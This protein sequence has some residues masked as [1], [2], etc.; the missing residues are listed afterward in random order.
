MGSG[1]GAGTA[2]LVPPPFG[3]HEERGVT[4]EY[5]MRIEERLAE[6]RARID[7]AGGADRVTLVAVTKGFGPEAP[8]AALAAGVADFGENYAQELLA[9]AAAPGLGAARWHFLGALQTNKAPRLAPVVHRW[10]GIDRLAA[11]VAVGRRRPGAEVFVEVNI[12]R[13]PGRAGCTPEATA[14]LVAA[15]GDTGVNV[16]GL[17]GVAP[18]GDRTAAQAGFRWLAATAGR[19]GLKE[20]S[21]G[22]SDDFEMAIA[23]GATTVRLG[24]VLFGPRP[25]RAGGR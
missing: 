17:M 16:V 23:E 5:R 10:H 14:D 19:L 4:A 15:L 1:A 20:L 9:K 22:M 24:R 12:A 21:M 3:E 8:L 25:A 7:A 2:I 6:V 11:G 18:P 13:A